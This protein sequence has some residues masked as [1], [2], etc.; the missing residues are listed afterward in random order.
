MIY[1]NRMTHDH[2]KTIQYQSQDV[3]CYSKKQ[4]DKLYPNGG[5]KILGEAKANN[6]K[7]EIARLLLNKS[8]D[9]LIIS[10]EGSHSALLY[11]SA[12]YVC[13]GDDE[14]VALLKSRLFLILLLGGLGLLALLIYL[15]I[16]R[17]PLVIDP[18][19]PLPEK[20]PYVEVMGDDLTEK[21]EVDEGGGSVSMIYTL[22]AK[23]ALS[24]GE[25]TI[26]FKN[27]NASSHDVV[28][29]LYLLA[30]EK[31]VLVARS[32][33]VEPGYA[34]NRLDLMS[35][36]AVLSE[37]VYNGLY[38]VQCYD[39]ETGEK[40]LVAPEITGVEVSVTQ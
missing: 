36:A 27:P 39:P 2:D 29:E 38:K 17:G 5:Y 37:G 31:E 8:D 16:P 10:E 18:D 15:L 30:G 4:L 14:Y 13:V 9:E 22:E 19:H 33:R 35:D 40:A 11:K 32:G 25:V 34:L 20:D 24:S 7:D 3:Y 23:A 26:Y 12:G 1:K 28:I 21:A 6:K